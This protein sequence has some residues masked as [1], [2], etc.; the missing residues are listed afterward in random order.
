MVTKNVLS[1]WSILELVSIFRPKWAQYYL[2]RNIIWNFLLQDG[3]TALYAAA[4][5]A[6]LQVVI[7][8]LAAKANVNLSNNVSI[9]LII[10]YI[11]N[12]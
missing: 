1:Y 8:L 9:L 12:K 10:A 3:T 5:N 11:E 6:H 7:R 4:C 2:L